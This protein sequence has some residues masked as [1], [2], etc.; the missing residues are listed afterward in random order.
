MASGSTGGVDPRWL[1]HWAER[2][3]K[4][5]KDLGMGL[6]TL[7][8]FFHRMRGPQSGAGSTGP[9]LNHLL[10][11]V[12]PWGRHIHLYPTIPSKGH[13]QQAGD[14]TPITDIMA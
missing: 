5:A 7:H 1:S 11:T 10:L 9:S 13:L 2:S 6:G 14:E 4:I 12:N 3:E 8:F